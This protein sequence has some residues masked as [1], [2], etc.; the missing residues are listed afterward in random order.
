MYEEVFKKKIYCVAL[1][2]L[3]IYNKNRLTPKKAFVLIKSNVIIVHNYI[4][5]R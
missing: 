5:G 1:K 4:E 3:E 2:T